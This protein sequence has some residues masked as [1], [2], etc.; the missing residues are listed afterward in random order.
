[1][2]IEHSDEKSKTIL[3]S[4]LHVIR[5]YVNFQVFFNPHLPFPLFFVSSFP[6]FRSQIFIF[7]LVMQCV[8]FLLHV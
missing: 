1:M 4:V 3:S 2:L 7:K 6:K 8:S 5:H